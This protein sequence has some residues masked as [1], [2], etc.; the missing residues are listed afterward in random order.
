MAWDIPQPYPVNY[1][2]PPRWA[3]WWRGLS[4]CCFLLV[5]LGAGFWFLLHDSRV[6]MWTLAAVVVCSL[7]FALLGGW[8]L[9]QSGVDGEHAQGL[10]EYNRLQE[11]EWQRWAQQSV[12]VVGWH[13]VFAPAVLTPGQSGEPVTSDIPVSLPPYPGDDWLAEEVIMGLLSE[14]Q[15]VTRRWPLEVSLPEGAGNTQ[16]RQFVA[17]WQQNGLPV[18][19]LTTPA[20]GVPAYNVTLNDWLD[21]P[22]TDRA[23][24]V[25]VKHWTGAGEHT[26]GVVAL[27]LAPQ[28]QGSDIPVRCSLHRPMAVAQEQEGTD[29]PVFL[30][31]QPL[32]AAMGGLWTDRESKALAD[33]LVI[34]HS[35]RQKA[36]TSDDSAGNTDNVAE[37]PVSTPD[38]YWLPHWLGQTGP[39]ADWFALSLMMAM[40]E[41]SGGVQCGLF[42]AGAS[43][44]SS[45]SWILSSVS[46]GAF[47]NE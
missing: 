11:Y 41:H 46:A 17:H 23:R 33:L 10:A 22:L 4:L 6:M 36:G 43:G 27:L 20:A 39:C 3:L 13:T 15:A 8:M 38:Q 31:Y 1:P 28:G 12:Q 2:S 5:L 42:S 14:L 30:H 29:F 19:R 34:A 24:L 26:E 40:A 9:F 25:I 44:S 21:S 7:L 45:S 16:W 35:Q 37:L 47:V 32:T 18:T